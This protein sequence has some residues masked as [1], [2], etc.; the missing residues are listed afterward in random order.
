M[1]FAAAP[2]PARA[3]PRASP[4]GELAPDPAVVHYKLAIPPVPGG[5]TAELDSTIDALEQRIKDKIASPFDLADLAE[6]HFQ[7]A[8]LSGDQEE[9]DRA[10]ALARQSLAILPYPNGVAVV[11]AKIE[12]SRHEFREAIRI[13]DAYAAH[14]PSASAEIVL[15]SANLA[16]GELDAATDAADKAVATKPDASSYLMRA[17]VLQARGRDGEA[18]RSFTRAVEHE[19]PGDVQES[20]RAR[21]LWARFLIRRG[22]LAGARMLADEALRIV[23]DHP[24]ALAQKAEIALRTGKLKEARDGFERAFATSRQVRYLI[25]YARAQELS[26]D[27]AGAESSRAQVEKLIRAELSTRGTGHKLDL[28]EVLVDRGSSADLAEAIEL[29]RQ[30]LEHR[31]SADTRFQ[32]ARALYRS[33]NRDEAKTQIEAALATGVHDV[34]LTELAARIEGR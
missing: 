34:R 10:E 11:L 33:G 15:A 1:V 5:E 27:R 8:Q 6:A 29:G 7:S 14:K 32:L 3:T 22:E 17:L 12:S 16:L 20:A 30:E 21:A 24:L 13:A 25:D 9:L 26:K 18:A 23:P 19:L 31:P 2:P 4:R 28:V